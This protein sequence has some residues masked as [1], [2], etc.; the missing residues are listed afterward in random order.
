MPGQRI[1]GGRDRERRARGERRGLRRRRQR[2]CWCCRRRAVA[3]ARRGARAARRDARPRPA[4][5]RRA[6]AVAAAAPAAPGAR[7]RP[8]CSASTRACQAPCSARARASAA[9]SVRDCP[10]RAACQARAERTSEL[11]DCERRSSRSSPGAHVAPRARLEHDRQRVERA[12]AVDLVQP[13]RER[14][15]R[16]ALVRARGR[17]AHAQPAQIGAHARQPLPGSLLALPRARERGVGREQLDQRRALARARSPRAQV[18]RAPPAG[19]APRRRAGADAESGRAPREGTGCA[20]RRRAAGGPP[21]GSHEKLVRPSWSR[22][23][24]GLQVDHPH[25]LEE[26]L[27]DSAVIH[28]D[29]LFDADPDDFGSVD[30]EL[31]GELFGREVVRHGSRLLA[32]C[33]W[34][35]Q[36]QSPPGDAVVG[37]AGQVAAS[38]AVT[39]GRHSLPCRES[40]AARGCRQEPGRVKVS[41]GI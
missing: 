3:A 37:S 24:R 30:P 6:R 23:L 38:E 25:G 15:L 27:V 36:R 9:L 13:Q 18:A 10:R 1:R 22:A 16:C 8:R 39:I 32:R 12:G 40:S 14:A 2:R 4:R 17:E 26:R 7:G 20:R 34:A 19:P 33:T 29:V 21:P 5:R 41:S 35:L 28:G 11:S 31:T